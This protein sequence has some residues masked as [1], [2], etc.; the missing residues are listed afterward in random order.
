MDIYICVHIYIYI[1]ICMNITSKYVSRPSME[2][3]PQI[4]HHLTMAGSFE[5]LHEP[6]RWGRM[7]QGATGR[8][9]GTEFGG[10][11]VQVMDH[12]CSQWFLLPT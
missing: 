1:Y 10:F 3:C 8:A 5:A 6:G 7:T 9:L 4:P 2:S 12:F 11:P